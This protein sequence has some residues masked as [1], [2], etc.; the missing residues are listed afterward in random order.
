M[1]Q[2]QI[3]IARVRPELAEVGKTLHVETTVNHIYT[4]VPATVNKTPFFNP[5]RKTSMS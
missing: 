1:M 3:G 2:T 4:S 5:E